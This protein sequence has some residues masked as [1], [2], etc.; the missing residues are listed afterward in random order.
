MAW[1]DL[2]T[3]H[4]QGPCRVIEEPLVRLW[5]K[6]QAA[7]DALAKLAQLQVQN[8]MS[9]LAHKASELQVRAL[10]QIFAAP[11][12][13]CLPNLPTTTESGIVGADCRA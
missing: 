13:M 12:C 4:G 1:A 6:I 8:T 11:A 5:S 3:T 9:G 10:L 7:E 2:W